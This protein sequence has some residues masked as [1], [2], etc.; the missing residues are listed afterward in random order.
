MRNLVPFAQFK[1]LEKHPRNSVISKVAG[2]SC[3]ITKS[4]IPPW[5]FFTF[6]EL[7][8]IPNLAK[9]L[10]FRGMVVENSRMVI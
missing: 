3:N 5:V 2:F 10:K 1:K 4:I 7:Y 6:S 8:K 9:R